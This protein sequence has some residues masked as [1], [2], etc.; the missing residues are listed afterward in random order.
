MI[1]EPIYQEGITIL[2]VYAPNNSFNVLERQTIRKN[3]QIHY[4][5]R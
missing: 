1:N 5:D 2:N 3:R 4:L